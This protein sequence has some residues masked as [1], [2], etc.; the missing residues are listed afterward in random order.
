MRHSSKPWE[1]IFLDRNTFG[2]KTPVGS[3]YP[4]ELQFGDAYL[5]AAAP[6]L[7]EA[8]EYA[9]QQLQESEFDLSYTKTYKILQAALL[10]AKPSMEAIED[11]RTQ[12]ENNKLDIPD[13][14]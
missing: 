3:D 1:V 5:K 8:C 10:K 13:S 14:V 11:A 2:V 7:Y 6:D 12:A 4:L 9:L